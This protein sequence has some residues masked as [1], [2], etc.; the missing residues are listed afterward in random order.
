M[1]HAAQAVGDDVRRVFGARVV[2]GDD[3]GVGVLFGGLCHQRPF[4]P[5]AVA[6][7]AEDAPQFAR[8]MGAHAL[9]DVGKRR[10]GVSVINDGSGAV[11]EADA[12]GA[13]GHAV[14]RGEFCRDVG[15]R[16]TE[17]EQ[18][19]GGVQEVVHVE[20]GE[21]AA[22]DGDLLRIMREGIGDTV[23]T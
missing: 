17:G 21:Q 23:G 14:Q 1:P 12:L 18:A 11:A 5:V 7:A 10:R 22:L 13:A 9:Q 6:A 15:K 19:G 20:A 8:H 4:A 3:D 16:H 2:V